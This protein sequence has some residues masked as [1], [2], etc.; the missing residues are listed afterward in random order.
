M[1]VEAPHTQ[2]LGLSLAVITGRD[3][4][5]RCTCFRMHLLAVCSAI[6]LLSPA[7]EKLRAKKK[8][9]P[10]SPFINISWAAH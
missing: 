10:E 3:Y 6:T 8:D 4:L 7:L 9:R 2:A 1:H 5:R